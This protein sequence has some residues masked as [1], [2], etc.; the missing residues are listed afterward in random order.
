MKARDAAVGVAGVEAGDPPRVV[1]TISGLQAPL[2]ISAVQAVVLHKA[3]GEA[4][5]RIKSE[6]SASTET[7]TDPGGPVLVAAPADIEAFGHAAAMVIAFLR[8]RLAAGGPDCFEHDG[9]RWVLSGG[10][11]IAAA[12]GLSPEAVW[13]TLRRHP[14][15]IAVRRFR[16]RP[17][18]RLVE[19]EAANSAATDTGNPA[20]EGTTT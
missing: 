13:S 10:R 14:G 6:R 17:A 1:L 12:T 15:V 4:I 11:A 3:L 5:E 19:P 8:A 16:G 20:D 2:A 7:V 9:A 18:Y